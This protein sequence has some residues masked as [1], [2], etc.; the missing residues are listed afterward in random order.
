MAEAVGSER[1]TANSE[2]GAVP[3]ATPDLI[4]PLPQPPLLP[5]GW[6][7]PLEVFGDDWHQ[8]P[9]IRPATGDQAPLNLLA[10]G[11]PRHASPREIPDRP[12]G[13]RFTGT[14]AATWSVAP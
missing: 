11:L 1:L 10:G 14:V 8:D 13:R 2:L 7:R 5:T 12:D 3:A 4:E 9:Q 6:R